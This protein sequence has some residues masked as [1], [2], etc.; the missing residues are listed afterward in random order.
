MGGK[1]TKAEV[2]DGENKPPVKNWKITSDVRSISAV[3]GDKTI[4]V[5]AVSGK[6]MGVNRT[7]EYDIVIRLRH[8]VPNSNAFKRRKAGLVINNNPVVLDKKVDADLE[9]EYK[10]L[11]AEKEAGTLSLITELLDRLNEECPFSIED[12]SNLA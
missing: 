10:K 8:D 9:K 2:K 5:Q 11:V 12:I 1:N 4:T 3:K 6:G 7:P